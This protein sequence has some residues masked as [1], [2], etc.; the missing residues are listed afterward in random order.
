MQTDVY[1]TGADHGSNPPGVGIF[2]QGTSKN[3]EWSPAELAAARNHADV[4]RPIP[5]IS[6]TSTH[7]GR[8]SVHSQKKRPLSGASAQQHYPLG[9]STVSYAWSCETSTSSPKPPDIASSRL[10]KMSTIIWKPIERHGTADAARTRSSN[11]DACGSIYSVDHIEPYLTSMKPA[12]ER[13]STGQLSVVTS[14]LSVMATT[15]K[16]LRD[17]D[18]RHRRLSPDLLNSNAVRLVPSTRTLWEAAASICEHQTG[19]TRQQA[20]RNSASYSSPTTARSSASRDCQWS[21]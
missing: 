19:C 13:A 3:Q 7:V 5:P 18:E 20:F 14:G 6:C 11:L 12:W 16:P 17:S 1:S 21:Y 15:V 9:R 10:R 8:I 4:R 2:E